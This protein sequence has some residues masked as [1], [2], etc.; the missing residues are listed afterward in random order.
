MK[1]DQTQV[2]P[3][4]QTNSKDGWIGKR[5]KQV[6]SNCLQINFIQLIRTYP[7]WF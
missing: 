7:N 1:F 6:N 3:L 4:S 2:Q 5:D